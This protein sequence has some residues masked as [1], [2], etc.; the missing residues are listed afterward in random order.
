MKSKEE[1]EAIIKQQ[2]IIVSQMISD[3][4]GHMI[5][6]IES[7]M[8]PDDWGPEEYKWWMHGVVRH[9]FGCRPE[10]HP[11]RFNQYLNDYKRRML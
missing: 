11:E 10:K 9:L 3:I 5:S 8:V 7:G 6:R 1:R 2:E 4:E